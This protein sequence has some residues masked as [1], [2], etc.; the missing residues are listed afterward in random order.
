MLTKTG[1]GTL[2]L[3]SDNSHGGTRVEGGVL[4]IASFNR[5]GSSGRDLTL[6]GGATLRALAGWAAP[7]NRQIT[8]NAGGGTFNTNGFDTNVEDSVDGDAAGEGSLMKTGTGT[9]TLTGANTYSG[10]TIIDGGALLANNTTG[11]ATGTGNVTINASGT[12]G[13][14]G[15]VGGAVMVNLG[16][17][18]APTCVT[19]GKALRW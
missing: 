17:T 1:N 5:L 9:F 13:G 12:L 8:L 11:S 15:S 7:A 16:G 14:T 2:R 18:V 4:E 19:G 10:G 3:V 6:A